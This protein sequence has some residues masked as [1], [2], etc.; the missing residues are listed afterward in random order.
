MNSPRG[1]WLLVLRAK[2]R[3]FL[4]RGRRDDE[5]AAEIQEHVELLAERFVAQGM[6]AEEAAAAARRQFGNTTALRE[7]RREL[8]TF[9]FIEELWRDA[10]YAL[11]SLWR[12]PGFAVVSIVTLAL[13]IGA[14]T[15]I[16]SV[17]DNVLLSPFPYKHAERMVFPRI[18]DA[19]G[20]QDTGRAGFTP[21]EYLEFA[22]NNHVF[23]GTT[24]AL[25]DLVLYKRGEGTEQ[26]YGAHVTPGTFEFFGMPALYGRVLEPG[27]Y[28]PGAA[29]V[30]V[31]RYK[32]WA[33]RFNADPSV[34]HQTFVLN[35]TAR[36][37]VGIMPPRFA[38]YEADVMIPEK[39]V[40]GSLGAMAGAPAHWFMVG[41]LRPGVSVQQAEADLTI[42][43]RRLAAIYPQDYPAHFTVQIAKLGDTVVG[44]FQ[45]TLYTVLAAV[46]LLLLIACSNVANLMLAR[47]TLR[48]K[49]IAL[50]AVLGAGR[51]R[52]IR[53]LMV[54]SLVL[55]VAGA[56]LGISVASGGLKLL[57]AL[58]PPNLIPAESAIE[59]NT[60]VLVFTFCVAI[61][62]ALIFG[63]APA[64]Q[65]ARHDLNEPLRDSGKGISG[66]F[67]GKWLREAVVMVEVALSLTL[68]VGAGLLMRNFVA[69]RDVPLGMRAD[70]VF[71]TIL[72]LPAERYKT[73]EQTEAL[74]RPLFARLKTLPGVLDAAVSSTIPPYAADQSNLEIA[75]KLN[76][77]NSQTLLQSVSQE[78]FAALRIAFKQGRGFTE[79]EIDD[80]RKLAVV[81]EAFVRRYLPDEDP[82]GRRVRL[83]ALETYAQPVRDAW[84]EIIGVAADVKNAGLQ[85]PVEPGLYIPYTIIRMRNEVLLV[86]ASQDPETLANAVRR[87]I[88]RMDS[89]IALAYPGTLE[90]FIDQRLYAGPRFGFVVMTV[91]GCVGLILVTVGVYSLL[92]YT[93]MQKTHEIGIRMA[94]G[95][96]GADVLGM[97]VKA[98]LRLVAAGLAAGLVLSF[99]LARVMEGQ[100][101]G[102]KTYDPVTLAA[103][104]VLLIATAAIACWIPA[105]RATRVDPMIALRHE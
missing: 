80:R 49:E 2:L 12:S 92:A 61:L 63:L 81:N 7:D 87:E 105:R 23:D 21:T 47:S 85:A 83:T 1:S 10:R 88:W 22:E 97:I 71:Q 73:P 99:A 95:A 56:L 17:I 91:F 34:L 30:F 79:A 78:Y 52:L 94:L 82:I 20:G 14:T 100:L 5:F 84:F 44:H 50:R 93:T 42:I 54:E 38:W 3:G 36:T 51:M 57:V 62:T 90:N 66:G 6:P 26:F 53:L 70:H 104:S 29:P 101:G 32:T 59:L 9:A 13:G 48:E 19:Q 43:A 46:G 45:S 31:M 86:R 16:F 77:E 102:V 68:L 15:A 103:T 65:S 25:E 72:P 89:G 18:H 98:A 58:L 76:Q 69:L 28:E 74:F 64:L 75:G 27:D 37:L 60:P 11:R 4:R 39:L 24:A 96:E 55:A 8:Q 41:R 33:E 40:Q 67:R 35:G